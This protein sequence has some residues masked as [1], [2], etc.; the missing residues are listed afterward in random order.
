MTIQVGMENA[1]WTG[2]IT[3]LVASYMY[4]YPPRPPIED[5]TPWFH[6]GGRWQLPAHAPALQSPEQFQRTLVLARG[7]GRGQGQGVP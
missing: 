3:T 4:D 1:S 7:R 5:G 2:V 6:C